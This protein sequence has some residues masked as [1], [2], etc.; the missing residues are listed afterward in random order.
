MLKSLVR[1]SSGIVWNLFNEIWKQ[2]QQQIAC[3]ICI[4]SMQIWICLHNI[5]FIL[6]F[7]NYTNTIYQRVKDKS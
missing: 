4:V 6:K 2:V 7:W 1:I 3:L 5:F